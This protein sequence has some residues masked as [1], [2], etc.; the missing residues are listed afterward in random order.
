MPNKRKRRTRP[1]YKA[2]YTR[3][4]TEARLLKN[5]KRKLERHLKLHPND[6]QSKE[7]KQVVSYKRVKSFTYWEKFLLEEEKKKRRINTWR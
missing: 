7:R 5:K 3:Y 4:S 1:G 2:C 6:I